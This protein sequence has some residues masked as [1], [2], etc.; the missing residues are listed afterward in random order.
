MVLCQK[1]TERV[2]TLHYAAIDADIHLAHISTPE[3]LTA[4]CNRSQEMIHKQEI[5]PLDKLLSCI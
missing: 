5:R 2:S 3:E 4:V 1:H